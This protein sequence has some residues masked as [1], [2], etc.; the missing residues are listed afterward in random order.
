M[1]VLGLYLLS[2]PARPHQRF[3]ST[4]PFLFPQITSTEPYNLFLRANST[5]AEPD[6]I[7]QVDATSESAAGVLSAHESRLEG[8]RFLAGFHIHSDL[9]LTGHLVRIST[10]ISASDKPRDSAA[11]LIDGFEK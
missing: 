4:T 9:A 5:I 1:T 10:F 6:L 8:S 2:C 7:A 3:C 11:E